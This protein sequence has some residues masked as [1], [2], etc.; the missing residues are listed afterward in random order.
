MLKKHYQRP[1]YFVSNYGWKVK[2]S[3]GAADLQQLVG[4]VYSILFQEIVYFRKKKKRY[5]DFDREL[6]E[7]FL[8]IKHI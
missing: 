3:G 7:I 8:P 6:L 1:H 2:F 4:N 5:A